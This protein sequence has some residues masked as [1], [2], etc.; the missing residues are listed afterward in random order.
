MVQKMPDVWLYSWRENKAFTNQPQHDRYK[1]Q[2]YNGHLSQML[3]Q[4]SD[5][6]LLCGSIYPRQAGFASM[7]HIV[8]SCI[9]SADAFSA[10]LLM[11]YC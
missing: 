11:M 6:G 1:I 5:C 8:P 9:A 7:V 4:Q 3:A 2:G 10:C